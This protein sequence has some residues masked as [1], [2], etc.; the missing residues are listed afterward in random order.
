MYSSSPNIQHPSPSPQHPS[1]TTIELLAP[2]KNL[3]CGIAAI[4][5]GADAVYIGA[6]RFGARQSAGNSVEDIGKL[7]EYAHRYGAT[8][9]V[10]INTIIYNDEFEDT[11]ALVRELVAVGV[12]AFLLQ[13]MG[14]MSKVREIVPDTVALHAST[15]CDTRTWEKAEW[16]SLQGF[17]R[18]VLARELSA[19]EINGIHS[20][21]PE[22]ELEAFVHGALCVSYSG[23][24]YVSQYSFGRSA[25]R[26][27]CAQFCRLAFDLKDSDGKTIE[28]QRHLLS[29]KDMSQIDNLETL[30]RSGACA[31]KI[32]GRL[33]DINYVKNVVS[34]YSKRID[35]IIRKHPGE[36]RRA[37]LG[38]VRYSFTPDLKKTFNRGYT[39]YFLK[40]RQA[41]IF[42][43]DTPKALGE[44]VGRVKEIRRDSFNVSSTANFANGDGLCFLSRDAEGQSTRLEGF[45]VNRAVGNRLYPFKMPRGLKPGMGLYRNQDQAFDKEL[46]GKTAE[47]K[48]AIK[49]WFGTS[50]KT[51]PN[52]SE[53]GECLADSRGG[54]WAKAEVIGSSAPNQT[55]N[56]RISNV[57][58]CSE[59]TSDEHPVRL[60]PPITS[61]RSVTDGSERVGGGLWGVSSLPLSLELAQKPQHDNIIR[62]LTKL[63]NTVY[64]CTE[65]EIA[66]GADMYFVPSSILAELRRMVIE[67]LDEQVMGMQRMAIHRKSVVEVSARKPQ[68]TMVNPS[69]YQDLP[70]LYN[71]SNDAARK[72][73]EQQGLA[74]VDSAFEL[75][76]PKSSPTPSASMFTGRKGSDRKGVH[77]ESLSD[78]ASANGLS[79]SSEKSEGTSPL[80][81]Q[82]R[83]CIRYSLGYCVKR[84]GK[85]P[86]WREP[87]FLELPDKRRFRLE[88]DCKDC[89]MNIYPV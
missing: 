85:K 75:Q 42:S 45:R 53:G 25:N 23:V 57:R 19:E 9:H 38:R 35:E 80:L 60:S 17:D 26:G 64:E 49:M 37:S 61:L 16:L 13:D 40:G 88:F 70:Y 56:E 72:F 68:I 52:P 83:H 24:C 87:L 30:M 63:G 47:R 79:S 84:G 31:F 44:F 89:Q 73:Y 76:Y 81:M 10:T 71:I 7:C 21:L 54:I 77:A 29:L 67:N 43:P 27:A 15:Q 6:S 2:A 82:C 3:G 33:K 46:S 74:K 58:T 14:L 50:S 36:F 41:D 86:T 5:H 69:Q 1:P 48:I 55:S 28:H 22:L 39:N 18:V 12:D 65:V 51:F 32:E 78:K 34:A 11:L 8:V 4:E 62:Q 66:D 20:R 59:R